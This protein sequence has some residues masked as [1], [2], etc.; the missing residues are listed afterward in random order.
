MTITVVDVLLFLGF[1]Q[2]SRGT[3]H[4]SARAFYRIRSEHN[5]CSEE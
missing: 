5:P 3:I 2:L 1:T 4:S